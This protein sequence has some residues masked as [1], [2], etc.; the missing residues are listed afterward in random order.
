M[1][2]QGD[3][4]SKEAKNLL[5]KF[6]S[7]PLDQHFMKVFVIPKLFFARSRKQL[8]TPLAA[9]KCNSTKFVP[10]LQGLCYEFICCDKYCSS[11]KYLLQ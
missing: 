8:Q 1:S 10:T 11:L 4:W 7:A 2:K 6:V 5:M 3:R 9:F